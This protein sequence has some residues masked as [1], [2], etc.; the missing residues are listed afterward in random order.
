MTDTFI[1]MLVF[2]MLSSIVALI[3]FM[4]GAW[5]KTRGKGDQQKQA[6]LQVTH[7]LGEQRILP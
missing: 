5:R 1:G 3:V 4:V 6:K 2:L 7:P